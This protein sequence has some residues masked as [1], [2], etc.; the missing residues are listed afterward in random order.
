[1]KKIILVFFLLLSFNCLDVLAIDKCTTEEMNRL[2]ELAKNV[3]FKTNYEVKSVDEE[4]KFVNVSYNI[5]ILNFD[6]NLKIKYIDEFNRFDEAK[7]ITS[8]VKKIDN[9]LAGDSLNF[10]I[11]SRTTNLCTDELLKKTTVKLQ[12]LNSYY[13]FNQEKCDKHPDFKYCEKFLDVDANDFDAINKEFDE[14]LNPVSST[15]NN[16]K[17]NHMVLFISLGAGVLVIGIGLFIVIKKIKK[18][19]KDDL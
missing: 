8:D 2:K 12:K 10:E 16:M 13:Y 9:L 3:Q 17:N 19:R 6:K 15:I 1:M 7:I 4:N 18:K 14:F 11:Y 5:E